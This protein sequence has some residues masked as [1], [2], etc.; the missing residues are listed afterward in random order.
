MIS[1]WE[2]HH[3]K[4]EQLLAEVCRLPVHDKELNASKGHGLCLVDDPVEGCF[5]WAKAAPHDLHL[6]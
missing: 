3:L 4:G 5:G 2:S 6:V 1:A